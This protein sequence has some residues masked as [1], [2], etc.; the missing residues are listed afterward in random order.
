[1]LEIK[2]NWKKH[3]SFRPRSKEIMG[4]VIH[5]A[6]GNNEVPIDKFLRALPDE[7]WRLLFKRL[8]SSSVPSLRLL[9]SN[10][11]LTTLIALK[12]TRSQNGS[13]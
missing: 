10:S 4:N 13:F 3:H 9:H 12:N 8:S 6:F 2:A 7:S 11:S 5:P 1:M